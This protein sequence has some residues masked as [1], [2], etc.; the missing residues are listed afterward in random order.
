MR[1]GCHQGSLGPGATRP[2]IRRAGQAGVHPRALH[3]LLCSLGI[4]PGPREG[5]GSGR[6]RRLFPNLQQRPALLFPLGSSSATGNHPPPIPPIASFG[7]SF[8]ERRSQFV[9]NLTLSCSLCGV[10]LE[11]CNKWSYRV[12]P[13]PW[14]ASLIVEGNSPLELHTYHHLR[15]V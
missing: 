11:S 3:Q 8:R 10:P 4:L 6:Q 13:P 12:V 1:R 15:N 14:P 9:C 7:H 5:L 2:G